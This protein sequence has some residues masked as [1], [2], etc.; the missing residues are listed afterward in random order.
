M[1]VELPGASVADVELD[2]Q[3]RRLLLRL[4]GRLRLDL[5]LP[6]AVRPAAARR[7]LQPVAPCTAARPR[8]WQLEHKARGGD[9]GS[10][11]MCLSTCGEQEGQ[12]ARSAPRRT[13]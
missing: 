6:H 1:R 13:C 3:P 12:G 11:G 4:P 2:V 10:C 5:P 7:A 9:A 8:T